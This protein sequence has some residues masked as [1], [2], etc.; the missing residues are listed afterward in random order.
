M[1]VLE[2]PKMSKKLPPTWPTYLCKCM[3]RNTAIT[4]KIQARDEDHAWDLAWKRV[5]KQEGG[6]SCLEV[7]IVG[8]A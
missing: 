4:I 3:W 6:M 2:I 7:K 1:I 5:A 8:Y